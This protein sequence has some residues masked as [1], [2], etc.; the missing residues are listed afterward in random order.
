[1][2]ALGCGCEGATVGEGSVGVG[3]GW[4]ATWGDATRDF[5]GV[6]VTDGSG[7]TVV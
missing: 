7:A 6:G 1:M 3:V 2:G 4:R 5:E